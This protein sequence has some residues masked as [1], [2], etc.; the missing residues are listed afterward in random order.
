ME[1]VNRLFG[2]I[3]RGAFRTLTS[4]HRIVNLTR[5]TFYWIFVAPFKGKVFSWKSTTEQMVRIGYESIP[6]VSLISFFVGLIIAMQSAYQLEQFGA[7]IYVANLV[8]VSIVRELSPLLTAIIVT[9]R[10]GSAITAEIGTMKVSEEIDALKTMGFN[11]VKFLV[12]PRTLAMLIMVPC[13]TMIGDFIGIVGG[14]LIAIASLDITS[15]RYIDQTISA[16][17]FRDLFSGLVKSVFFALIIA[18]VG[19][20]EGFNVEGGA[21]GVG[22]STTKS[23]VTSIFFIIAA[24]VFFTALFY[25]TF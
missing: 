4:L 6:I 12:V 14:Y 25:S 2:T 15:I 24:D 21:E 23:V 20:Y 13:L 7:T 22:K 3:G 11:P 16:L 9:G 17:V 10:S 5:Q 1:F 18:K 19:S 8:A